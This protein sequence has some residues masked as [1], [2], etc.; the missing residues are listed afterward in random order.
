MTRRGS[1]APTT[2]ILLALLFVVAGGVWYYT[3]Y[4][5][6]HNTLDIDA[7]RQHQPSSPNSQVNGQASFGCK[8]LLP[9]IEIQSI[10][11]IDP[12]AL[13]LTQSS[14]HNAILGCVWD[15]TKY[16]GNM[17]TPDRVVSFIIQHT[18]PAGWPGLWNAG[19]YG[20]MPAISGLGQSAFGDPQELTINVLS[21]NG[22]YYIH[23]EV[24]ALDDYSG[25]GPTVSPQKTVDFAE[26]QAMLKAVDT[27]LSKY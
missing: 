7:P 22:Q 8:D 9:D 18:L 5:K 19:A 21:T 24:R 15:R 11:G 4:A 16:I 13:T 27:N 20:T 25:R 17:G 12:S 10:F 1:P 3:I 23:G 2:F 14:G 6:K 26:N